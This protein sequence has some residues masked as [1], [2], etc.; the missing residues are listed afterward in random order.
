MF[1]KPDPFFTFSAPC[2]RVTK[3]RADREHILGLMKLGPPSRN[4]QPSSGDRLGVAP[5]NHLSIAHLLLWTATTSAVLA[6]LVACDTEHNNRNVRRSYG[7]I[8]I[9]RAHYELSLVVAPVYGAALAG[10]A[11]AVWRLMMSK[12]GFPSQPGHWLLLTASSVPISVFIARG[13]RISGGGGFAFAF[14]CWTGLLVA[15]AIATFAARATQQP[16]RWARAWWLASQGLIALAV[17]IGA[18][19]LLVNGDTWFMWYIASLVFAIPALVSLIA[20]IVA[21]ILDLFSPRRWDIFHWIGVG[22]LL[23]VIAHPVMAW[24]VNG[25]ISGRPNWILV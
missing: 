13:S 23:G 16:P 15:S 14:C 21:A 1:I 25:M 5:P 10:A 2:G 7:A 4:D 11:L 6:F 19:G 20:V 22:T 24:A 12:P 18:A 3:T 8:R 17:V 9:N